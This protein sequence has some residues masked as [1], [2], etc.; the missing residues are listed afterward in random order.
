MFE[1]Q[2]EQTENKDPWLKYG[3]E[4]EVE[5]VTE[6][7]P[8]SGL[9]INPEKEDNPTVVDLRYGDEHAD[10]KHQTTP[11][12]TAGKKYDLDPQMTV[13]FNKND[14]DRY[15]KKLDSGK[16]DKLTIFYWVVWDAE[17][18]YGATIEAMEGVWKIDF[19]SLYELTQSAPLHQ[20]QRRRRG[21]RNAYES[22]LLSLSDME[23]VLRKT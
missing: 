2:K 23:E 7:L 21:G 18:K 6:I 12:F 14:R 20:Y 8:D 11:F 5:F 16:L 19:E 3:E 22:Y 13:T 10:L 9:R 4:K 15:R 17:T 1:F